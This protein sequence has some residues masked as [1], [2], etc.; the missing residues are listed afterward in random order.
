MAQIIRFIIPARPQQVRH[1]RVQAFPGDT[2]ST[3]AKWIFSEIHFEADYG[4][5]KRAYIVSEFYPVDV[6]IDNF[7]L[8]I[9]QFGEAEIPLI[10]IDEFNELDDE[11]ASITFSNV[12]K[13]LSDTGSHVTIFIVRV[14]DNVT[15]L[16]ERHESIQRCTE[17]ILMPRMSV[18]ERREVLEKRLGQLG[19]TI[20]GDGKW[21][22]INLSKGLPAY[23]HALGK[24]A[25]ISALSGGRLNITEIDVDSAINDV[26]GASQQ[27]LR[28]N[29]ETAIRSN[30][31]RA[32]F[33]QVLTACA[34]AKVDDAGFFVPAAVREP[35]ARILKRKVEIANFQDT[36]KAFAESRGSILDRAGTE[37]TYRFRFAN[38]AMQP[39]VIMRGIDEKIID[40]AARLA[41]SA[42]EQPDLFASAPLPRA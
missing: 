4:E 28:D 18:S 14:A 42:P 16:M 36:L 8:E 3:V 11:D 26:I 10:I 2:F 6:T 38:P 22:I 40:E 27:T 37:R 1:I 33:R 15:D 17:Q 21:K 39:Y 24:F 31:T 12:I 9:K 35:L 19:M 7:L 13:A 34:L 23:V 41:L 32:L 30:N 20:D 25:T 29:Y 5:G